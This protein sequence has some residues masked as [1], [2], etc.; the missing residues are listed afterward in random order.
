VRPLDA[1]NLRRRVVDQPAHHLAVRSDAAR[2]VS[3]AEGALDRAHARGQEAAPALR[4]GTLGASVEAEGARR[5]QRVRH[6]MLAAR[7]RLAVGQEQRAYLD[8]R[9]EH[10]AEDA[11]APCAMTVGMPAA[12]NVRAAA[13]FD[14]IPPVPTSER[15]GPA[16]STTSRPCARQRHAAG[17]GIGAGVRLVKAGDVAQDDE[18]VGLHQRRGQGREIVVVAAL[19][20]LDGDRVVLVDD[21]DGARAS[22]ARPVW[23]AFR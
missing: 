23:R 19:E 5:P 8:A 13:T 10:G 18:Q 9:V 16:A 21:G 1:L 11:A 17:A 14:A 6:P 3:D 4:L 22:S 2:A 20:L 12:A 7:G 15:A